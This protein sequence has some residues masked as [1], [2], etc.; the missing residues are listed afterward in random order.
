MRPNYYRIKVPTTRGEIVEVECLDL[1]DALGLGFNLGNVLK[2]VWRAGRKTPDAAEDL[3]K[4]CVYLRRESEGCEAIEEKARAEPKGDGDAGLEVDELQEGGRRWVNKSR[5]RYAMTI[6]P[7]H[8]RWQCWSKTAL[9]PPLH[10]LNVN[11]EEQAKAW[12]AS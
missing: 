12:V 7:D 4:A 11:T 5:S 3:R 8:I 6:G 9:G 1:I 2:Y 10:V